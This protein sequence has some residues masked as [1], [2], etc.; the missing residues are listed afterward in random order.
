MRALS[1]LDYRLMMERPEDYPAWPQEP[2]E[3][4][5]CQKGVIGIEA[6][7]P[8]AITINGALH[9]PVSGSGSGSPQA[10]IPSGAEKQLI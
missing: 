8:K 10:A 6:N 7:K 4:C 9:S 2:Q 5:G 1:H 3:D